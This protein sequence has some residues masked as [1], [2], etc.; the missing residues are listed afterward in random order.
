M[1]K[2]EDACSSVSVKRE[3]ACPPKAST[4]F[5]AAATM[6]PHMDVFDVVCN[7]NL[8]TLKFPQST[9]ILTRATPQ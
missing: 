1:W 8:P 6:L 7:F 9:R 5:H 3:S 2:Q 4:P